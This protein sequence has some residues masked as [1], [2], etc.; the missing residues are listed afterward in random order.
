MLFLFLSL[1][2]IMEKILEFEDAIS[3]TNSCQ[4]NILLGNGFSIACD[5]CFDYQSL[6]QFSQLPLEIKNIF[7]ELNTNDFELVMNK[8]RE[9]TDYC[10]SHFHSEALADLLCNYQWLVRNDLIQCISHI[11]PKSFEIAESRKKNTL[12]FLSNFRYIFTLNYDLLLY[13]LLMYNLNDLNKKFGDLKDGYRGCKEYYREWDKF[14]DWQN[15]F[16]IHGALHLFYKN[17]DTYKILSDTYY[18]A[19]L[20]DITQ[21]Y[22]DKD[23]FPLV[24]TEG[25]S[26]NKLDFINEND[27]LQYCYNK[28]S[29]IS[30]VLFIHGHSL[31]E[32]DQ[33]IFDAI[34]DNYN[35]KELYISIH[36][37]EE[38]DKKRAYAKSRFGKRKG[39]N[40][41]KLYFYNA[42]S[43][44]LWA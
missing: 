43:A 42:Q 18:G 12:K 29:E 5:K 38:P 32:T 13:W 21:Q 14:N 37:T 9:V 30:G 3:E 1:G 27:Y 44:K 36:K 25:E 10:Y 4:R 17:R 20:L 34:N 31:N 24:V 33:H 40:K 6:F 26:K 35:I 11:H 19:S 16:Y 39:K 8:F 41:I 15:V 28:L 22:Q 23:I 2:G 7:Q